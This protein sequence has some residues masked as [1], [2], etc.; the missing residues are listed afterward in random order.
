MNIIQPAYSPPTSPFTPRDVSKIVDFVVHHSAGPLG[1]TIAQID[2]FERSRTPPDIFMPYTWLIRLNDGGGAASIYSGRPV[3]VESAATYG[4]NM[5]S[6]A[7]CMIGD[8][9]SDDAGYTGPPP[10]PMIDA[11]I[12]LRVYAQAIIPSLSRTIGHRDIDPDACPGDRL[13]ALLPEIRTKVA[14]LLQQKG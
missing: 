13:Y 5:T 3:D 11:L 8:F 9:Q 4:D 2:A 6:V 1:Q 14:A 7:V 12:A 10:Q